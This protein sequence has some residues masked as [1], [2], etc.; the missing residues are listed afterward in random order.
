MPIVLLENLLILGHIV[1][2]ERLADIGERLAT[3]LSCHR[4][5]THDIQ[6][7]LWFGN[8]C[9]RNYYCKDDFSGLGQKCQLGSIMCVYVCTRVCMLIYRRLYRK[10]NFRIALNTTLKAMSFATLFPRKEELITGTLVGPLR[11]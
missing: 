5:K 9:S 7:A 11:S 4:L 2:K 10:S 1:R 8:S 6:I 3:L